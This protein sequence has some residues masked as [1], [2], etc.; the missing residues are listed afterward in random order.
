MF[1]AGTDHRSAL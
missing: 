1:R